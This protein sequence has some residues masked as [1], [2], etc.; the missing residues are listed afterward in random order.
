MPFP[1]PAPEVDEALLPARNPGERALRL[2]LAQRRWPSPALHPEAIVIGSDQV[3]SLRRRRE[4]R[5]LRKP[6]NRDTCREQLRAMSGQT[7]RFDTAVAVVAH[8][9]NWSSTST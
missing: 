3:A 9:R 8:A 7:A 5:I 1:L 2:A 6:G 4:V